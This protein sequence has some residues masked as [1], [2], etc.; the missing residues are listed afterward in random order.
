M[1]F[2]DPKLSPDARAHALADFG[3]FGEPTPLST[4]S[5]IC[6]S[7]FCSGVK[8]PTD[9]DSMSP[10]DCIFLE[11]SDTKASISFLWLL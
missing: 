2:A 10:E 8:V 9:L 1:V 6:P 4:K 11:E 3:S 7:C 5:P